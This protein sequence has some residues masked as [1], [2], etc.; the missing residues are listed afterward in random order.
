[1]FDI[2]QVQLGVLTNM[3]WRLFN[4][5]NI[6]KASHWVFGRCF[7]ATVFVCSAALVAIGT[8]ATVAKIAF[9]DRSWVAF[10][11]LL[12]TIVQV[13]NMKTFTK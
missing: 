2:F 4:S 1:M 12:V 6:L 13:G 5:F 11:V 3:F 8:I 9:D 7:L 10:V